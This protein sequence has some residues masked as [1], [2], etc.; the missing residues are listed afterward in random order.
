MLKKAALFFGAI[1]LIVGILGF[2]PQTTPKG[3]LLGIFHVNA[4]HNWIHL[5]TGAV[6]LLCGISGNVASKRFFQIF[7]IV[8]GLVAILGFYYGDSNILGLVANNTADNF[9]HAAI[10]IV[11]LALGFR[12][13][14]GC[15]GSQ[16]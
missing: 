8:Y 1:M 12:C 10:A 13:G 9:L 3:L 6:S 5:L 2:V 11:S 15:C 14:S 4:I 16:R 7:G